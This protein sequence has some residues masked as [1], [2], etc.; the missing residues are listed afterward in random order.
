MHNYFVSE[1]LSKNGKKPGNFQNVT[2]ADGS[3]CKCPEIIIQIE[4][5]Y[6]S[7]EVKAL[8][9]N[10]PFADLVIGNVG[11][12]QKCE[13]NDSFQ[14]V[15]TLAIIE[16]RE[17]I[18]MVQEVNEIQKE[19]MYPSDENMIDSYKEKSQKNEKGSLDE[20]DQSLNIDLSI[21]KDQLLIEQAKDETLVNVKKY[22]VHQT[23][24]E[25][26]GQKK[27]KNSCFIYD[28]KIL[29]QV[30]ISKYGEKLRQIVVPLKFRDKLGPSGLN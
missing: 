12:I 17:K 15:E 26:I 4:T 16:T 5:K 13:T 8:I 3:C 14:A 22:S 11:H 23:K 18:E 1:Y 28:N 20:N 7:G 19:R 29:Y 2:L 10:N 27:K 25:S 6:I 21:S 30:F 9:M 24:K